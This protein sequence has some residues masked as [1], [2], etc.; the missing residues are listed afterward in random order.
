MAPKAGA[1]VVPQPK[2]GAGAQ[3]CSC[4]VDCNSGYR[5]VYGM[6]LKSDMLKVVKKVTL[7]ISDKSIN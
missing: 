4:F 6:K 3:L 5:W 2:A 1:L 7:W